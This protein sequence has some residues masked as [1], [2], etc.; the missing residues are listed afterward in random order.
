[1]ATA[2]ALA[3]QVAQMQGWMTAQNEKITNLETESAKR[4]TV[5]LQ[6][7]QQMVQ[8]SGQIAE[9]SAGPQLPEAIRLNSEALGKL[10][11]LVEHNFRQGARKEEMV[12]A[13]GIGQ[14]FKYSGSE[15][16]DFAEW[17]SK[18]RTFLKAKLGHHIEEYI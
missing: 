7:Q 5:F 10:T 1:M 17:S 14:P 15:R 8:L 2:E 11:E 3:Q 12:D 16:Q 13:K 6:M 4:E 9:M 18:K